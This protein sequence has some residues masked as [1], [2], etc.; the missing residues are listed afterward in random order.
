MTNSAQLI[1]SCNY[2]TGKNHRRLYAGENIWQANSWQANT[3]G[4]AALAR[5]HGRLDAVP[6][7]LNAART[8]MRNENILEYAIGAISHIAVHDAC[9]EQLVKARRE[10]LR[11][12]ATRSPRAR[13]AAT[14]PHPRL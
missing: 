5:E 7:L 10:H 11:P 12:R 14:S 9:N 2:Y 4:T 1:I 8:F 13:R 6:I 3:Y